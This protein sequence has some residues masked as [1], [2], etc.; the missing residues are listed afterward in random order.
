MKKIKFFPL[1]VL[2]ILALSIFSLTGCNSSDETP[3]DS[4]DTAGTTESTETTKDN[5]DNTKNEGETVKENDVEVTI[6]TPK[7]NEEIT[8]GSVN[9][10][11]TVQGTAKE[12]KCKITLEDETVIGEG[13]ALIAD[14]SHEFTTKITY[15]IPEDKK[16]GDKTNCEIEVICL[17]ENGNEVEDESIDL[18]IK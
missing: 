16:T 6:T 15:N 9:I 5:G 4:A 13:K 3:K 1:L 18:T 11:G 14:V 17:D 2:V 8:G 12:V 10:T 7:E